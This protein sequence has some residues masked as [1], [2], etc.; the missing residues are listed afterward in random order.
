MSKKNVIIG[1]ISDTHGLLR[2]R[3][4][5][6]LKGSRLIVHAGDIDC[7]EVLD[8]LKKIAPL[9]A[10]K[11]NMDRGQWTESLPTNEVAEIE[12][13]LLYVLHDE[14][15]LDLDPAAAGFS[16]VISGHTHQ[17]LLREQNGV[18]FFNPGSAGPRRP[19]KPVTVGRL[20]LAGDKRIP[21]IIDID[22]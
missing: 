4:A 1:I 21:K 16:A 8:A 15:R 11:G 2:K 14:N 6:A 9:V 10:V 13:H 5:E 12:N 3:V 18:L 20:T 22:D 19:G 7:P 17:P